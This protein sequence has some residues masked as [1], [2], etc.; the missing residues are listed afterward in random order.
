M[1]KVGNSHR[2]RRRR[3]VIAAAGAGAT[4]AAI[5]TFAA[6]TATLASFT[7]QA[8]GEAMFSTSTF[9]F[10]SSATGDPDS[11]TDHSLL[12]RLTIL[13][14]ASGTAVFTTPISLQPGE[15]AFAPVFLRTTPGT[16]S[17]VTVRVSAPAKGA[18]T[19][20]A[21]WGAQG[22]TG[23]ITYAARALP[24]DN[25]SACNPDVFSVPMGVGL[26]G[27]GTNGTDN[28]PLTTPP[29]T[30]TF[31]LVAE[32]PATHMVCFRFTLS[33]TVISGSPSSN[34]QAINPIWAFNGSGT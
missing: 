34:G 11:F 9:G 2:F 3:T 27:A 16:T 33:S 6:P 13:G 7:D 8:F 24:A 25:Q 15:S 1:T 32:T 26:Y 17:N 31:E 29:P 18:G 30:T 12:D 23:Y 10:Q 19:D 22:Q 14:A 5:A 21:L 4:A 28:V 20:D